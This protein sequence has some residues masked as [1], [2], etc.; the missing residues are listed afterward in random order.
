MPKEYSMNGFGNLLRRFGYKLRTAL[1]RF[2]AGRYGTDKLNMA[3]LCAGLFFTF[4]ST[5]IPVNSV[6]LL[7]TTIAYIFMFLAIFR[8]LSRNVYKRYEENRK[9]LM[10]F[11]KLKDKDHRYYNCPR[12][13]QQVRVPKGK[14]KISITC[15]K[16]QEKF[17]KT[18]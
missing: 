3:I 15:P 12:C 6:K 11:Q 4:L 10:F 9:F 17:I 7:F 18:T 1:Q 2:M 14:G 8:T 16:C 13:H 5:L